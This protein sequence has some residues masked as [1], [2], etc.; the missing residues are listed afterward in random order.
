[1]NID[2]SKEIA[3]EL[4]IKETQVC[5]VMTLLGDSATVP[6]IARYRKEATESLDE[7]QIENIQ[8]RLSYLQDLDKRKETVLKTI[9]EQGKL[10]DDLKEKIEGTRDMVELEDLYLPYKPKRKTKATVAIAR[11]LEPL[12]DLI[13]SQMRISDAPD[14]LAA[15]FVNAEKEVLDAAAAWAGAR[16]ICAERVSEQAEVRSV[17]RDLYQRNGSIVSKVKKDK[18]E[19]GAKYKDYFD[20][21][22]PASSIPGH[23]MLAI[24]RGE[25]EGFLTFRIVVDK[26][27]AVSLCKQR[28][29]RGDGGTLGQHLNLAVED[30]Y[31]RLL[32]LSIEGW[33]RNELRKRAE[34]EAISVFAMNLRRLLMASPLGGKWV[35]GVDPGIRTGCKTVV[36]DDKGDLLENTVIFT[37]RGD[38]ET[39]RA[40]ETV[41]SLCKKYPIEAVAIGNGTASRETEA[42]FRQLPAEAINSAVIIIV[43]ES[44]ASIYSASEIARKEFPDQDITVRGAVSIGRRLQDPL[45]ELVKIDPKSVGVGQYQHD[46]DQGELKNS[47]D[48]VVASCVN[49]VGVEL[50]TASARLLSYVSG[51]TSAQAE[52]IVNYRR[53]NGPFAN[54]SQVKKAPKVGPKS[55]EQ[56]AGFL[57]IRGA[58]NP[59]DASAVHPERYALVKEMAKDLGADVPS[60]IGDEELRKRIDVGRYIS[61]AVGRP[62][63]VDI[64]AELA[65]PGRDPR[66]QFEQVQF[67][68]DVS[69]MED[70]VE[71]MTLQGVVTNVTNFGAFVDIGVHQD[72]LVHV[73]QM[74]NRYVSDPSEVVQVDNRIKVKVIGVDLARKRIALSIKQAT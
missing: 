54:R 60:L 58:K 36:I 5:A 53:E 72:G 65:K 21:S 13:W 25:A 45:A 48:Q 70:L 43:N 30:G 46:V 55:F 37:M 47:L 73:S 34:V 56:A 7:V 17:L 32:S 31:S 18:E 15:R 40:A 61:D 69:K 71:G 22:E 52:S 4:K 9:D 33:V 67:D 19:Q 39:Q 62:T 8:D 14:A 59:L 57:R 63:L 68:P 20:R 49:Q 50:N 10:T 66:E 1:M 44:G 27:R 35:L 2:Y 64:M 38:A 23:R 41:R 16:D 12:A 11:G 29:I 28:V 6:F 3:T 42:F 26:D 24:R 74:A 51:L